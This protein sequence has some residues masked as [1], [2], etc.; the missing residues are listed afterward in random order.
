MKI[1][2]RAGNLKDVTFL[3]LFFFHSSGNYSRENSSRTS[4]GDLGK[5]RRGN[6]FLASNR[7]VRYVKLTIMF[8]NSLSRLGFRERE[9]DGMRMLRGNAG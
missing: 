7:A 3:S 4:N 8:R 9:V 2:R 5:S 1:T 6:L